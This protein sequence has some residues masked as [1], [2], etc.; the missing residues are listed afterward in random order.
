MMR[1]IE[2]LNTNI[3]LAS[4][5]F[6]LLLIIKLVPL[7]VPARF[8]IRQMERQMRDKWNFL[9]HDRFTSGGEGRKLS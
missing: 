9:R 7:S 1:T 6:W 5:S 8:I 4:V 2:Y 3:I